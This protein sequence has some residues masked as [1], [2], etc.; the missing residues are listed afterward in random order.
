MYQF[1]R[2]DNVVLDDKPR[3]KGEIVKSAQNSIWERDKLES[4]PAPKPVRPGANEFVKIQ[5]RGAS[6]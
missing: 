4:A 5:S 3:Y 6:C 1:L 2:S